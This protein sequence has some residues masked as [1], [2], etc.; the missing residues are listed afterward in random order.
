M[1]AAPP[2]AVAVLAGGAGLR[3]GGEKALARL[4]GAPLISY[5]LAAARAAGLQAVIV[6]KPATRLPAGP[7]RVLREPE[8]PR[9]PLC[10]LVAA[11]R[12]LAPAGGGLVALACDM[13]FVTG[14]LLAHLAA[15]EGTAAAAPAGTPEPLLARYTASDLPALEDALAAEAPMRAALARLQPRLIGPQELARFG[16]PE[17]LCASVNDERSLREAERELAGRA[18]PQPS[19]DG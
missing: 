4:L 18:G 12:E 14:P 3:I 5:P 16:D 11:L 1:P 8:E 7:E 19:P 10:G 9:H 13:P 17:L 2:V 15:A 6:A